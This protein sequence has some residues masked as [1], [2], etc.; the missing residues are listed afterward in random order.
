MSVASYWRTGRWC[1]LI[2]PFDDRAAG[3]DDEPGGWFGA[4]DDF[5]VD[6]GLGCGVG[7]SLPALTSQLLSVAVSVLVVVRHTTFQFTA[8]PSVEQARALARHEGVARFAF[9]Q[10]LRLH[11]NARNTS[12]NGGAAAGVK[13]PWTGFDLITDNMPT[14]LWGRLASIHLTFAPHVGRCGS[15]WFVDVATVSR[16]DDYYGELTAIDAIQHP[17]VTHADSQL[18]PSGELLRRRGAGLVR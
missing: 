5:Q 11:L 18:G 17:I 6:P 16:V 3:L 15:S 1:R 10:G 9:N 2:H 14:R 7:G 12:E 13:I 8:D 4:G